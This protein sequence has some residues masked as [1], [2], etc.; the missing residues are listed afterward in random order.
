MVIIVLERWKALPIVVR[1]ALAAAAVL[2][3]GLSA[4]AISPFEPSRAPWIQALTVVSLALPFVVRRTYPFVAWLLSVIALGG[5]TVLFPQDGTGLLPALFMA[6]SWSAY[7]ERPSVHRKVAIAGVVTIGFALLDSRRE[8]FGN[9]IGNAV[10]V[11]LF[12]TVPVVLGHSVRRQRIAFTELQARN[13]EL[14]QR[15][16][17]DAQEAVRAERV[18]IARELHDVAAHHVSALI[19]RAHSASRAA[20]R[21]PETARQALDDLAAMGRTAL[22][23]MRGMVGLLR[24]NSADDVA[25][26]QPQPSLEQIDELIVSFEVLGL[27]VTAEI[28]GVADIAV[29]P[30]VDL[31]AYRLVQESLTNVLRHS[32]SRAAFVSIASLDGALRVRV[33]DDGGRPT[34]AFSGSGLGLVGMRERVAFCGG[35]IEIGPRS[36]HAGWRVAASLPLTRTTR[37][38][39]DSMTVS[40]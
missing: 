39:S 30:E 31:C 19:I 3:F 20:E 35:T 40:A 9:Q 15:R 22:D 25:E 36:D 14:E 23:S 24:S 4:V 27:D 7:S 32:G 21:E 26:L 38:V 34:S 17:A 13:A 18:R 28:S 8:S 12:V 1:D 6:Y 37:A 10:F 33:D 16:Q 2:V 29:R 5:A 11:L